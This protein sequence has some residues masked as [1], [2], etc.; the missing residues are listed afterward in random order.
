MLTISS[1]AAMRWH[2][3]R[4]G[5]NKFRIHEGRHILQI[6]QKATLQYTEIPKV[7]EYQYQGYKGN[8]TPPSWKLELQVPAN[9]M[10]T[11]KAGHDCLAPEVFTLSC[12]L[13]Q[14]MLHT[15]YRVHSKPPF[16]SEILR[17]DL[18]GVFFLFFF[19]HTPLAFT[20]ML[21]KS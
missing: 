11:E 13:M 15:R 10:K 5:S 17:L 19:P 4:S 1:E 9:S 2:Q 8:K 6:L 3:L 18:F 16:Y 12:C 14:L 21:S 7:M 20:I